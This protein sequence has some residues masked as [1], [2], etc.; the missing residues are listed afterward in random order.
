MSDGSAST[1]RRFLVRTG[2][3]ACG[4]A[5]VG[6][7]A[8]DRLTR[9]GPRFERALFPEPG[10]AAVAVLP[11]PRYDGSLE[12]LLVEGLRAV[13]ARVR[14]RSVLLKP[15][16]VEF[17]GGPVNTDPQLVGAAVLALRRLG[18]GEVVVG[19]GPGHRRDTEAVV[20]ASGLYDV[21]REVGA[22]FVDLNAAPL[23]RRRLTTRYTGL[24]ELWLPKP[25]VD[26]DV[27]VSMPKLKTHHWVGVTLSLKNCFGCVPGRAYGWPKNVLHWQG[28]ES[29]VLDVAAAVRP[30]LAI[31][32]GI[33]GMEGDGPI[34][35]TEKPVG[36]VVVASDPVAADA[37]AARL[38]G[39]DG[40]KVGYLRE[41]GRFLGQSRLERIEQRGEDPERR[42]QAF[43]VIDEFARLRLTASA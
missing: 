15:N 29:S 39:I 3:A 43:A 28:I 31:V 11:A 41:A 24:G 32:D 4:V 33:V 2:A 37:T 19:E 8:A 35:G 38:M 23:V 42:A 25:V 34:N 12:A 13:G 22:P 9:P 10:N 27:V 36:V 40:D 6:L 7:F 18:A 5:S 17:T 21:L 30:S 20:V 14:G 16:L 1:R 26:A